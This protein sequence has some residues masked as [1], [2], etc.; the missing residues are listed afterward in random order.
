MTNKN[1][2]KFFNSVIWQ[3]DKSSLKKVRDTNN[4]LKKQ[5][6]QASFK[7]VKGIQ[8]VQSA[9]EKLANKVKKDTLRLH[10]LAI[11][12]DERRTRT[13]NKFETNRNHAA[14]AAMVDL[15][16]I[17]NMEKLILRQKIKQVKSQEDLNR[18]MREFKLLNRISGKNKTPNK[19]GKGSNPNSM[20]ITGGSPLGK[21]GMGFAAVT[22]AAMAAAAALSLIESRGEAAK[23]LSLD[24][25]RSQLTTSQFQD[26][27]YAGGKLNI[28]QDAIQDMFKDTS[29][30]RGQYFT[31]TRNK[32]T[33]KMEYDRSGEASMAIDIL[34]KVGFKDEAIRDMSLPDFY[35]NLEKA[36][37][38][39]GTS[40]DKALEVTEALANDYSRGRDLWKD[41]AKLIVE[42][43]AERKKYKLGTSDKDLEVWTKAQANMALLGKGLLA[44]TDQ[45]LIGMLGSGGSVADVMNK[46]AEMQP[47]FKQLG[48]TIGKLVGAITWALDKIYTSDTIKH[49][50]TFATNINEALDHIG[51]SLKAF[52]EF[53]HGVLPDWMKTDA[54]SNTKSSTASGTNTSVAPTTGSYGSDKPSVY[55]GYDKVFKPQSSI[56]QSTVNH[57]NTVTFVHKFEGTDGLFE[58]MDSRAEECINSQLMGVESSMTPDS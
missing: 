11:K 58:V 2:S 50:T 43:S 30:K 34:K 1:V 3:V 24:A 26:V 44:M 56:T 25:E 36:L 41:N 16:N 32:K 54:T 17:S 15:R 39:L 27:V 21:L 42:A 4:K 8:K 49:L 37:I 6:E 14:N 12:E 10:N 19:K 23:Q 7:Q 28:N 33:G 40:N 13:L 51:A 5:F 18:L 57:K 55:G 45:F 31:E 22:G 46:M 29:E 38:K 20:L 53:I 48:I 35:V 9:E 47:Y 52:F